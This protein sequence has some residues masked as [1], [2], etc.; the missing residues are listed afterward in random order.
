[1]CAGL[2]VD[3]LTGAGEAIEVSDAAMAARRVGQYYL[4]D[5]SRLLDDSAW[6]RKLDR[7]GRAADLRACLALASVDA[8]PVLADGAV[9]PGVPCG[10]PAAQ[11]EARR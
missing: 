5:L 11:P 8:V 7:A 10:P 9:V 3:R 6:A 1:V 2:L 4:A